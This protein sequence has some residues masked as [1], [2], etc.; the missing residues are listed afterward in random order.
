MILFCFYSHYLYS[1]SRPNKYGLPQYDLSDD[2]EAKFSCD[3]NLSDKLL[4]IER[5]IV[6]LFH[7]HHCDV[8]ITDRLRALFA[9][10]LAR[11]GKAIQSAGGTGRAK[12]LKKLERNKMGTRVE[13]Y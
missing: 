6:K 5:V 8:L 7:H 1:I 12:V 11:M 10:K 9:S 13:G 4:L 2:S 3:L